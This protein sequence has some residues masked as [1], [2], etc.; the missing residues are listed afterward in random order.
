MANHDTA[1]GRV[2]VKGM[3]DK[4]GKTLIVGIGNLLYRDDGIGA[5]VIQEMQKMELPGHVQLLDM[6]T[7]TMDLIYHLDGIKKLIV[8]DAIK[9]GGKPG[10]VYRLKPE[11]LLPKEEEPVSLHDIGLLDALNMAEKKGME[12][13]TVVIGIEPKVFGWGIELSEEVR[14]K[15]PAII[16][17]VFK[18]C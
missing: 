12:I 5:W 13:E 14:E 2:G 11:E 15:I 3:K 7:S 16:E 10:A 9:A 8:I 17:A 4:T 18:E 6:G 1:L